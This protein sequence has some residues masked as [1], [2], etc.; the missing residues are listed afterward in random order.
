MIN[1]FSFRPFEGEYLITNDA[2][3]YSFVTGEELQALQKAEMDPESEKGRELAD[4]CFLYR[5]SREDFLSRVTAPLRQE[6][7][8]LFGSTTLHIFILTTACN[9]QCIYCQARSGDEISFGKMSA[10]TAERAVDFALQSP[11]PELT[12]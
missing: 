1:Y 4:K 10:D 5:D 9:L 12:F 11:G 8:C 2:G 6:N 7:G 3:Y